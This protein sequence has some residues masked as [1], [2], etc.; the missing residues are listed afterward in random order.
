MNDFQ[1]TQPYQSEQRIKQTKKRNKIRLYYVPLQTSDED[2]SG[3]CFFF[4]FLTQEQDAS[5]S[6]AIM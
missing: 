3:A 1:H 5:P 6:A 4:F 2:K